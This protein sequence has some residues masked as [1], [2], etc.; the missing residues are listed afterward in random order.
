[1]LWKVRKGQLGFTLIELLVVVAILGVLA[2]VVVPNVAKFIGTGNVEAANV[3]ANTVL[4]AVTAYMAEHDGAIPE[5]TD[6]VQEYMMRQLKGTYSINQST[7]TIAGT[8]GWEGLVWSEGRW[9]RES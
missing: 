8:G 7:A 4:V 9:I 6:D 3:E 5:T 1:M 2:L